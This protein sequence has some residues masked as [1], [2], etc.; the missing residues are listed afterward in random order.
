[1][2]VE[3]GQTVSVQADLKAVGRLRI[4][5]NPTKA[6]VVM[7]GIPIGVTPFD[8]EV[9]VGETIV[10]LEKPGFVP[11]EQTIVVEGGKTQNISRELAI[12]GLSEAE[13]AAQQRGLSSFGARTIPR[14]RSTVDLVAGFPYFFESRFNVGAGRIAKRFGFDA[15]VSVRTMLARTELGLGGRAL[16]ADADPFSAGAFTG[17]YY[18]SK[19]LD[20]SG[21]N[22]VTWDIGGLV[23]L[24]A[25]THLTITF[26]GYL[27]VWSDRHCPDRSTAD[28]TKVFDGDALSVCAG[29]YNSFV[30]PG[31]MLAK[32]MNGQTPVFGASDVMHVKTL[33][34][35]QTQNDVFGRETNARFMTSIIAELAADQHWSLFGIFEGAPFQGERAL[36]TSM[37]SHTMFDRD[38]DLYLRLGMT[39]KF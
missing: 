21:R 22:G 25:I 2:R 32:D 10:R 4:L 5:S 6:N 17:I 13:L 31:G 35:W 34:G 27:E 9:E 23:S 7:N 19:L 38:Y 16:L 36:L 1:V 29:F 33:T 8:S 26:R 3:A 24:T 18:G 28:P 39:Y 14:G 37:F 12:A 15:T 30:S 11:F 20:N